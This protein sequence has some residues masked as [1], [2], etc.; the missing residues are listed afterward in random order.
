MYGCCTMIDYFL[1]L[2]CRGEEF[3]K[4]YL[5]L[6]EVRS[7]LPQSVHIMALTATA[8][9]TLRKD[10]CDILD[11]KDPVLVSVSPDKDNIK[12]LVAGH[13]TMDKTFGP[14]ANQLYEHHTNVGRTIIFCQKLDDCCKLYRYFRQKLGD[15]FTFPCGSPDLCRNRVVDMFHSCT[16][17]CIKDSIIKNFS[18]SASPLRVVIA[19]IAFGMGVDIHDIRNIVHFGACEDVEMYVQA[20]GRAG[21]DGNNSTA[22]LLTRKGAKQ[23]ISTS[24]KSYCNNNSKCRR[25]VLFQ[26]FD[27][28]TDKTKRNLKLC[29]CC[30]I[31]SSKCVCGRCSDEITGCIN[32]THLV[33][34]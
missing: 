34:V 7:I 20:V 26:D 1:F 32:F 30:D 13:V 4:E 8:T 22:L 6:G 9:K 14:I 21:R 3:R 2:L 28:Q 18:T 10:V 33:H 11:M 31:C 17:P 25:E 24:M 19:T 29:M 5:R 23:H 15:H 16:E 27:E 12:Y